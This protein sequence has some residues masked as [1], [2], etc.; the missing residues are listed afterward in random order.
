MLAVSKIG[1]SHAPALL[2]QSD[3]DAGNEWGPIGGRAR[4]RVIESN[5]IMSTRVI[6]TYD[7]Y[8]ALPNDGRRY[9][10]H[11]GEISVTPAPS[12]RHQKAIV[13]LIVVLD[14]HVKARRIGE[15][16]VSP[17]DC[18][19]SNVTV[20]QP[21]IVY[22]DIERLASITRRGVEGAPTLAIEVLSPSTADVDRRTKLQL[23]AKHAM[24]Y[25]W[26]VDIDARVI[27]AYRLTEGHYGP[28]GKLVGSL[29]IALPPFSDL[30]LDPVLIWP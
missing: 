17:I 27:E 1:H 18:I 14:Q 23:Y 4:V 3:S 30:I 16:Y 8:A 5:D 13:N 12:P 15:I 10:L 11:E 20:V 21:D 7:D 26:I 28:I 29:P 25:Y 24:Q 2:V 9:E 6:L 19:L 22:V